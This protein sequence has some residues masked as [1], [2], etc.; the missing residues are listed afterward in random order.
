MLKIVVQ[1]A[2]D[3]WLAG[4]RRPAKWL[5]TK[6]QA[7][8]REYEASTKLLSTFADAGVSSQCV[9][10]PAGEALSVCCWAWGPAGEGF[11]VSS[12]GSSGGFNF[13]VCKAT[14]VEVLW[15]TGSSWPHHELAWSPMATSSPWAL[16]IRR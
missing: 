4:D 11:A 13:K 16:K 9:L 7:T 6:Y 10:G 3:A 2:K 14:T 15:T 12:P 8:F 5:L 1:Y